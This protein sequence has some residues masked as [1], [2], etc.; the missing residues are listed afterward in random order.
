[1]E[2]TRGCYVSYYNN[3]LQWENKRKN[4]KE[5]IWHNKDKVRQQNI[6]EV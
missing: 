1:L 2:H 3:K 6:L 4:K 5:R